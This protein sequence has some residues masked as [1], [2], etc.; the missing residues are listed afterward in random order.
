MGILMGKGEVEG[1]QGVHGVQYHVPVKVGHSHDQKEV[2][3]GGGRREVWHMAIGH[4]ILF[5]H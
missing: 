5:T 4:L 1:A 2:E 3:E